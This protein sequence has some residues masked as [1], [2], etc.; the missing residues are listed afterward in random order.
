[1]TLNP[2]AADILQID[3]EAA[4]GKP[5]ISL[6]R[7]EKLRSVVAA[8]NQNGSAQVEM[9]SFGR[10]YIVNASVIGRQQGMA[11]LLLDST[12][13]YKAEQA[14]KR[15]TANVSHE[16]RTPLTAISG[17]AELMANQMVQAEDIPAFSQ[18][19][20]RESQRLLYL[21]E[22][23]LHLSKL[24]EG[25]VQG[26]REPVSLLSIAKTVQESLT[27]LASE[28][29]ITLQVNGDPVEVQGDPL[30]LEEMLRNLAEN[31]IKYSHPGGYV[32]IALRS[33]GGAAVVSV[34]DNGIGIQKEHQN[35]VFERF[36]RVDS[37]RSQA[38]GGTGLGLSIVKHGAEYHHA[39][40]SLQSE[41]GMGT[42]VE[43]RFPVERE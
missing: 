14:R 43:I 2:S 22:D 20:F 4:A 15:F 28:K 38:T 24:D 21:V 23:I 36:Y 5:L 35:K 11:I 40:V 19:I 42:T 13:A 18:K 37:S 7:D 41:E 16:L 12:D 27:E 34:A 8:A 17:Y 25:H 9:E 1:V 6:N 31:G 39:A 29:Q 32:T 33:E 10:I 3:R 30:L 26:K